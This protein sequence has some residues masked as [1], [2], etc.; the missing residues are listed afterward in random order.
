MTLAEEIT[1]LAERWMGAWV[2]QDRATLEAILAPDYALIVSATPTVLMDRQTWL[3]TCDRYIAEHF[4]YRDVVVRQLA[5]D[6]AVMSSVAVFA[7]AIDGIDRSG[8]LF[9]VDVWQ[10]GGT[11][12]WQVCTRYSSQPEPASRSTRAM[13][14]RA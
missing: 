9:L 14:E 8:E 13:A 3:A 1:A 11:G 7:A 5:P 12:G 4:T 2:A 6:M 10:R